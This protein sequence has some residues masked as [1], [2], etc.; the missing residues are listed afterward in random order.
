MA[1]PEACLVCSRRKDENAIWQVGTVAACKHEPRGQR[2]TIVYNPDTC[3]EWF[4]TDV[5]LP[6]SKADITWRFAKPVE[7]IDLDWEA[8]ISRS[9]TG[10]GGQEAAIKTSPAGAWAKKRK[11]ESK[12]EVC[13]YF[14]EVDPYLC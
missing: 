10:N 4:E 13:Q 5:F 3:S 6:K 9:G 2:L 11:L 7:R 12:S 8:V 14:L 1:M